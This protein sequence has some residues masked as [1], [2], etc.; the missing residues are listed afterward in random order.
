MLGE[1]GELLGKL[2][3]VRLHGGLRHGP[4]SSAVLPIGQGCGSI[5]GH[6]NS[7]PA[8]GR[9]PAAAAVH[10]LCPRD[11]HKAHRVRPADRKR[12]A[13]KDLAAHIA[14]LFFANTNHLAHGLTSFPFKNTAEK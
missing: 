11:W 2:G 7:R 8:A 13:V 12:A 14:C 5:H 10:R 9:S 6:G 4:K 1:L 3:G